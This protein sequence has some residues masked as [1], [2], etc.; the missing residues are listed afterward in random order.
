MSEKKIPPEHRNDRLVPCCS[1]CID[2]MLFDSPKSVRLD[3][4]GWTHFTVDIIKNYLLRF[5]A[6]TSTQHAQ[7]EKAP[8]QQQKVAYLLTFFGQIFRRHQRHFFAEPIE[9]G[10]DRHTGNINM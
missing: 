1:E 3:R 9:I 10:L 4:E 7:L 6:V 2:T 8:Q 5:S